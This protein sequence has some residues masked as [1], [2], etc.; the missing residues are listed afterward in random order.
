MF[1]LGA[2][3]CTF[4]M[5]Q[6]CTNVMHVSTSGV[7][8]TWYFAGRVKMPRN[9]VSASFWRA[10]GISFGSICFGSLLVAVLRMV[11]YLAQLGQSSR[12][13]GSN[14]LT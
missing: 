8:A 3:F 14:L 1:L 2:L 10:V 7:V 6:V 11:R 12:E 5:Q 13:G 9:V 4:W